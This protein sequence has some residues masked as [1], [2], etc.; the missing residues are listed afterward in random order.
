MNTRE[1]MNFN[2]DVRG[3][4][5]KLFERLFLIRWI[6]MGM[7]LFKKSKGSM[8]AP[9]PPKSYVILERSLNIFLS[10]LV[11]LP[12]QTS[13]NSLKRVSCSHEIWLNWSYNYSSKTSVNSNDLRLKF[14]CFLVSVSRFSGLHET[15]DTWK[16]SDTFSSHLHKFGWKLIKFRLLPSQ[17]I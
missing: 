13:R 17:S 6:G 10:V 12:K 16:A 8:P 3:I 4:S 9:V 15:F 5:T 1:Q 14:L 2:A 11:W 7:E